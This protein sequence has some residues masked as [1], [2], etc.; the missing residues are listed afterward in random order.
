MTDQSTTTRPTLTVKEA[1][2]LLGIGR[3]TAYE[4]VKRGEIPSIRIG[5]RVVVPRAAF[6][7]LLACGDSPEAA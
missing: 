3:N 1:A 6:E 5:S 4:A 2:E 7:R